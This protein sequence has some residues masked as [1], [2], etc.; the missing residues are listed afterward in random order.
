M[1]V[2][3]MGPPGSEQLPC[4]EEAGAAEAAVL[5]ADLTAAAKAEDGVAAAAGS[6]EQSAAGG[7]AESCGLQAAE[8]LGLGAAPP[9]E[10]AA[11]KDQEAA[12]ESG[13]MKDEAV[14]PVEAAGIDVGPATVKAE[15]DAS[16][17][18][19]AGL[20]T[21]ARDAAAAAAAS[22]EGA[23]EQSVRESDVLIDA[24]AGMVTDENLERRG[25]KRGLEEG[26]GAGSPDRS[27][28]VK[29][30]PQ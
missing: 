7:A 9:P 8:D 11:V 29:T 27:V 22:G 16:P 14:L 23:A 3:A 21:A 24:E 17:E 6:P 1:L 2:S 26:G 20:S 28:K 15:P 30:E 18:A 19:M 5:E 4:E 25:L 13:A 10:A 12:V